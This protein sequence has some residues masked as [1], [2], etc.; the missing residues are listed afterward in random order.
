MNVILSSNENPNYWN[1]TPYVIEAYRCLGY[2]CTVG[3]VSW[4]GKYKPHPFMPEY[5]QAKLLRFYIATKM[6]GVNYV[7]DI[8]LFPLSKAFIEDKVSQRKEGH[9]LCVGGEVYDYNGCYPVSQMTAERE[10]WERLMN[11]EK[12]PWHDWLD[13]LCKPVVFDE[14]ENP[15]IQPRPSEHIYFSDEKLIRRLLKENPVPI[16]MM[17]RGYANVLD[18]TID[19]MDWEID[20]NKLNAGKYVNAHCQRPFNPNDL[21]R[22]LDYVKNPPISEEH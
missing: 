8:D 13:W 16:H 15:Y 1:F 7:D 12:L 14:C 3:L 20:V 9:L 4:R 21:N 18:S 11:P 17:E 10:V 2:N 6:E 5:A 22:L 19:R